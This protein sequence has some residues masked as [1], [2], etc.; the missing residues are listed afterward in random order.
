MWNLP[1]GGIKKNETKKEAAIRELEE[2][3]GISIKRLKY[4][5]NFE[6]T[7]EYKN[8]NVYCYL[9]YIKEEKFLIDKKEVVEACWFDINKL[10]DD[11]SKQ[12][13]LA[14]QLMENVD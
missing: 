9:V 5:G 1:G 4:V 8:D 14:L 6:T 11:L 2:E 7:Q 10:P 13:R 3:V 12:S